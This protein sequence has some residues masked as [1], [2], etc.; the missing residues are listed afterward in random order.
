RINSAIGTI[1]GTNLNRI[2][3]MAIY[4][5]ALY[6]GVDDNNG[7][8]VIRW[9]GGTSFSSIM[10]GSSVFEAGATDSG[11]CEFIG[12]LVVYGGSLYASCG[13]RNSNFFDLMKYDNSS[14]SATQHIWKRIN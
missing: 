13:D 7:G 14:N 4:N 6:V 11:T 8:D 9:D 1:I 2:S 5:G 12:N 10:G 3:S